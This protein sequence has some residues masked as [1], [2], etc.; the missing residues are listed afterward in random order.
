[1]P[2][3]S[4]KTVSGFIKSRLDHIYVSNQMLHNIINS[5]TISTTSDRSLAN[6]DIKI[7]GIPFPSSKP[8]WRINTSEIKFAQTTLEQKIKSNEVNSLDEWH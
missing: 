6:I 5:T 8:R 3:H 2:T 7:K 1:M 4:A